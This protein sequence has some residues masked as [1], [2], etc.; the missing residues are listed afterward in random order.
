MEITAEQANRIRQWLN[1]LQD[2]NPDYLHKADYELGWQ[3]SKLANQPA[4]AVRPPSKCM[5]APDE[6]KT[7]FCP[8][9]GGLITGGA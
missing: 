8:K 2:L 9:C 1:A 5:C 4:V 3:I 7:P 6:V